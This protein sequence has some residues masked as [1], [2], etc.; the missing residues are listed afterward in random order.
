M[1]KYPLLF[2]C[3][4]CKTKRLFD[5]EK[6]ELFQIYK[7]EDCARYHIV[8]SIS[9]ANPNNP[10]SSGYNIYR[11]YA[12]WIIDKFIEAGFIEFN[13]GTGF[14]IITSD[15]LKKMMIETPLHWSH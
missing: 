9:P 11:T 3:V 6:I 4:K 1:I 5:V 14:G 2:E 13:E 10:N 15:K 7:C 8:V 12:K